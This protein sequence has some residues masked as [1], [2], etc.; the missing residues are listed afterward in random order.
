MTTKETKNQ[1]GNGSKSVRC[2]HCGGF[3]FSA[4]RR[5]EPSWGYR[6]VLH[7]VN[8]A[9]NWRVLRDETLISFERR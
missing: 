9:R 8:C 6:G 5:Y 2:P 3:L 1:N 4:E 7:C